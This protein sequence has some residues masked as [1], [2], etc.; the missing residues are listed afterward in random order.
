M[1]KGTG[2]FLITKLGLILE[3]IK[4]EHTVF[5]LPYAYIAMILAADGMPTLHDFAWITIAMGAAR[6]LAMSANR[7][8]DRHID[9]ENPRTAARHLPAGIIQVKEMMAISLVSLGVFF[10]SAYQ[11]NTLCVILAP[12]A[13]L[14]VVIYPYTKRFTWA[15][16]FILGFADGIAPAGAWIAVTGSLSWE[17]TLIAFAVATW[18][19]GFDIL[20]SCQ[21]YEF[22]IRNGLYSLPQRFGVYNA[23]KFAKIMHVFTIISFVLL[24]TWLS[25][26]FPYYIGC[27]LAAA[28]LT[29][30]HR[31]VSPTDLSKINLAFFNINGYIAIILFVCTIA[32]IY[33]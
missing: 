7:L 6:T 9:A 2:E 10:V 13:V 18:I 8:I 3:S 15:C 29:Y 14:V 5:A 23:M 25:L 20:Y 27:V 32:S 22:D 17:A 11:L 1:V 12:V 30:E 28:L 33:V 24:G 26:A 4:F 19:G 16:H 21:D 31:L